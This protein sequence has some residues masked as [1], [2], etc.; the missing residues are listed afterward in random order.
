MGSKMEEPKLPMRPKG[1]GAQ[2]DYSLARKAV[3]RAYHSGRV[4]RFEICDAHPDL[5]RAAR[6]CGERT[7]SPCPVCD[8]GPVF[9]VSYLFS[10]ELSKQENGRV[11][12]H[13]D[14]APL[15]KFREARLYTVEVCTDC[16]WNHVRSQLWVGRG[17][18]AR[19]VRPG[20]RATT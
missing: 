18:R 19:R 13:G 16:S 2:V 11:W 17:G 9:L 20:R 5:L 1:P 7:T 4:S 12:K 14:L 10:D 8:Y 15:M 3:L 6:F